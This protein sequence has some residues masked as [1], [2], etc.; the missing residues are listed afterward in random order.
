[1]NNLTIMAEIAEITDEMRKEAVTDEFGVVYSR[2]G[3]YPLLW[4]ETGKVRVGMVRCGTG[5][6]V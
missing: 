3:V 6:V 5:I 1:M 4:R 2:D